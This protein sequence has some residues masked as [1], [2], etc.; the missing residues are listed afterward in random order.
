MTDDELTVAKIDALVARLRGA[1]MRL[2]PRSTSAPREDDA[3]IVGR[4]ANILDHL[5]MTYLVHQSA[6]APVAAAVA[7]DERCSQ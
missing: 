2:D 6:R 5:S 4:A 3:L 7:H 1:S